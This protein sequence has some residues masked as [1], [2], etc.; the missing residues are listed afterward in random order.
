QLLDL[1]ARGFLNGHTPFSAYLG[2]LGAVSLLLYGYTDVIVS[3][4]RSSDEGNVLYRGKD[5]NHQYSKSFRFERMFDE[6]LQKYLITN[7]RYFSFVRP[8]Y[9]LQIGKLFADFPEFF[10]LFKSCNRNRSDSWC[11]Q[12]AKCLSVFLT[13]YPF[14]P[15]AT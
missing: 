1:N 3:N 15:P 7:G 11:G 6:Y 5:I 9:E 8:L 14:V 12:C 2:F 13:L 4:E 10:D